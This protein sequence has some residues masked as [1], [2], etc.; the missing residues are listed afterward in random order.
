MREL[1]SP[2]MGLKVVGLTGGIASGKST[3]ARAF[4]TLGVPVVDADQLAREVVAKGTPGLDEIARTFGEGVLLADGS[5]DRK[6]LGAIV[7][8]EPTARMKLNAITHPRIAQA[9]AER[10]V[11]LAE[12]GAPYSLY[13]AALIVENGMHRG[14][15]AL[16]VVAAPPEVQL[17]RMVSRDG[18]G[19]D[20]A[21]ARIAAQSSLAQKLEVADFVIH[22]EGPKEALDARV[23]EVHQQLIS[24]LGAESP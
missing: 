8:S 20:E 6:A 17:A 2:M 3:V 4:A 11:R 12:T 22:N 15:A 23:A 21:R 5:L 10:L 24:R 19:E 18:F 14:M 1:Y 13:E 16:I 9:A 7:F